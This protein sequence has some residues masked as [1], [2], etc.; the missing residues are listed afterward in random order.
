MHWL[1][2]KWYRITPWHGVLLPLALIFLLLSTLRR[3]LYRYGVLHSEKLPVPVIIVGNITVGGSGKTPLTL[4]LAQQLISAG[5]RPGI[6]SRGFGGSNTAPRQVHP[7][8][9]ADETGDEPLLMAQRKLCPVWIGR[10]RAAAGRALLAA[11]PECD[12]LI[13]D[14][15]LQ[16][17]RLQRDAE[18]VV[19]DGARLF[20]NN[21]PLPAGPLREL[22][23]RLKRADAVV[24]NGGAARLGI[25]HPSFSDHQYTMQLEGT[26]F[27]NLHDPA[28]TRQAD[29]FQGMKLRAIA[30]IG[31]PQRF[32]VQLAALGL[33]PRCA[34]FPDHY[35][36]TPDDLNDADADATLMTEK[37]AV[38]CSPFADAKCWALR[39]DAQVDPALIGFILARIN[40]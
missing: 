16:H 4:W 29:D 10:D 2:R 13:S 14:D 19:V 24:I 39:V 7:D 23:A 35:R 30:G 27:H 9:S 36:Y 34:P 33:R 12:L 18:I 38:K 3:A 15:G 17:Y 22:R 26:V 8:D 37:D 20:G 1:E 28:L 40:R 32:F 31:H 6:I 21:L 25:Q 5:H 11:H